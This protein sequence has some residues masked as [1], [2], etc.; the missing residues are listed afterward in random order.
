[1]ATQIRAIILGLTA[2]IGLFAPN[3]IPQW[4]RLAIEENAT[5]ASSLILGV[6]AGFA[7]HRARKEKAEQGSKQG[8]RL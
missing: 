2:V 3:L 4:L 8:A 6:W 5:L 1:M 7:G